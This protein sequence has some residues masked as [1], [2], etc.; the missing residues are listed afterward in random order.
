MATGVIQGSPSSPTRITS[1]VKKVLTIIRRCMVSIGGTLGCTPSQYDIQQTFEVQPLRRHPRK[2][3]PNQGARGVKRGARRLLGGG[4]RRSQA[5]APPDVGRGGHVD[6]K[7]GEERGEGSGRRGHGDLGPIHL[8][9]TR[10]PSGFRVFFISVTS[11]FCFRILFIFGSTSSGHSEFFISGTSSGHVGSST[12]HMPIPIAS[13]SDTDEHDDERMDV[14]TP[15]QQLRFSHRVGK[16][17]TR[18]MPSGWP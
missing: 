14:V 6:L 8:H 18:F 4:A 5:P 16:K 12:S 9:H 7:R 2:P 11:A 10:L 3:V 15:A 13:S 1:F 17:T